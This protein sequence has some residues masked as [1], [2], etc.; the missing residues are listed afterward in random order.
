MKKDLREKR[1]EEVVKEFV[2]T[3]EYGVVQITIHQGH[4]VQIDKNEKHRIDPPRE[5]EWKE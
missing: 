5:R 1:W 4:V 3:L 2:S